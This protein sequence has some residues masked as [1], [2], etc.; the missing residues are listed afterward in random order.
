MDKKQRGGGAQSRGC[1]C[2]MFSLRLLLPLPK[3]VM[4]SKQASLC[5][6]KSHAGSIKN[7]PKCFSSN[8]SLTSQPLK[9]AFI[10]SY[11]FFPENHRF[12]A[13]QLAPLKKAKKKR[14]GGMCATQT[15]L[16]SGRSDAPLPCA[17]T[18]DF[19]QLTGLSNQHA[20][21]DTH[22]H[23]RSVEWTQAAAEECY[24]KSPLLLSLWKGD[25]NTRSSFGLRMSSKRLISPDPCNLPGETAG[26]PGPAGTGVVV[27]VGGGDPQRPAVRIVESIGAF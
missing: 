3:A 16:Q 9:G 24:L 26:A 22:A 19:N 23:T 4:K 1:C 13:L 8:S 17:N 7:L 14:W 12:S 11:F 10:S 2:W 20:H 18:R 25:I 15:R 6:W 27:V 21:A 5:R